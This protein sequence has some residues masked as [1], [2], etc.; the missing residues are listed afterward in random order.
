MAS[1]SNEREAVSIP[2]SVMVRMDPRAGR[3]GGRAAGCGLVVVG[4]D[5]RPLGAVVVVLRAQ[6]L[7]RLGIAHD[8][9]D[10]AAHE[11][12]HGRWRRIGAKVEEGAAEREQ[13][14]RLVRALVG[15]QTLRLRYVEGAP[16]REL[17]RHAG[18]RLP[19]GLAVRG[20]VA[21][22]SRLLLRRYR[23]VLGGPRVVRRA[24]EDGE[25]GR[26]TGDDGDGLDGGGA[27][28]DHRDALAGEVDG[29]MRPAEGVV[30]LPLEALGALNVGGFGRD[31][32]P[33]AIT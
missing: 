22:E 7:R 14:A 13:V 20:R 19:R 18:A 33:V 12:A 28:A 32:Q 3:P 15:R 17:P 9:A 16:Q 30:R 26:L 21:V 31:R 6:R 2:V 24:L 8:R 23:P 10:L 27:G 11:L 4:I 25:R 1:N 5:A 29:M